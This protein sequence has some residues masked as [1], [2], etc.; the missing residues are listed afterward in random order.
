MAA[1]FRY[2]WRHHSVTGGGIIP[3]QVAAS[4][5]YDM[6]LSSE[7]AAMTIA[8]LGWGS[9]IWNSRDLPVSGA[10]RT[11]GPP[12]PLEFARQSANGR[13]TLVIAGD[14]ESV[15]VL[16]CALDVSSLNQARQVLADREGIK[17]AYVERSVGAWSPEFS[18]DHGETTGIGRWAEA[19]GLGG[20][21]W[22]A[23]QSRFAGKSTKPSVDQVIDHLTNLDAEAKARAEEYVRRAP[24]Q[25]RT[26]Y[27]ERIEHELGW[28]A[29]S[30]V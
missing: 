9:L 23:L 25:I 19:A 13:I 24:L 10:W 14:A 26:A 7:S 22:T 12:L 8:C 17:P 18:S 6:A 2:R 5:R 1:S 27:R 29:A 20:V 11:D 15:P 3:L 16:W 4:C 28:V 21:V 30:H